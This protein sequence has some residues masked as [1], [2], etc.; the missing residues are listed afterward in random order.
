MLNRVLPKLAT[1][2]PAVGISHYPIHQPNLTKALLSDF[3]S[4]SALLTGL[5]HRAESGLTCAAAART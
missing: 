3:T 1:A 4:A 2:P 5:G